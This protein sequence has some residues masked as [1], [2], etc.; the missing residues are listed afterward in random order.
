MYKIEKNDHID[1]WKT[2]KFYLRV[3]FANGKWRI[4]HHMSFLLCESKKCRC[5]MRN[6]SNTLFNTLSLI[7]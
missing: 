2:F 3:L 5:F 6:A 4:R 7:G 1:N